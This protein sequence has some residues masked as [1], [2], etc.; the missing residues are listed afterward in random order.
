[1]GEDSEI[2]AAEPGD[3]IHVTDPTPD[4]PDTSNVSTDDGD[5]NDTDVEIEDHSF[6]TDTDESVNVN[7]NVEAPEGGENDDALLE[8]MR[9][10][11]N[12]LDAV[13]ANT[14]VSAIADLDDATG[15]TPPPVV[16]E[17]ATDE[18]VLVDNTTEGEPTDVKDI[19]TEETTE[20]PKRKRRIGR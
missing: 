8:V 18:V 2:I 12:K 11:D 14:T 9:S 3:E 10:I 6:N 20:S 5:V 7:V 19:N 4:D 16:T 1:M 17:P 13:I 15:D